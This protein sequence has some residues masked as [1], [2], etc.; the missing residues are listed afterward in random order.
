MPGSSCERESGAGDHPVS[1]LRH[2]GSPI[3]AVAPPLLSAQE[4]VLL[5]RARLGAGAG[6]RRCSTIRMVVVCG[7]H[8]KEGGI[9][10]SDELSA[11]CSSEHSWRLR[12]CTVQTRPQQLSIH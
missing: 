1:H 5:V 10:V 12:V 6:G 9:R 2:A 11:M 7:S 3:R 4:R 8:L